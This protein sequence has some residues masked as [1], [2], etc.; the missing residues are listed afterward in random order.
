MQV[1]GRDY[2]LLNEALVNAFGF[3]SLAQ[4]LQ[5]GLEERLEELVGRGSLDTTVFKLIDAYNRRDQVE[6]LVQAARRFNPSNGTLHQV[7]QSLGRA[8]Q[9]TAHIADSV[10]DVEAGELEKLVRRRIP[11]LSVR[12]MREQMMRVEGQMCVIERRSPGGQGVARGSGFLIGPDA[13]LTNYHVVS[14]YLQDG[15][16][17]NLQVRFD[18]LLQEEG[19][20]KPEE[21]VVVSVDEIPIACPYTAGDAGNVSQPPAPG[22][23]DFA[24]LLLA[25]EAGRAPVG[26]D[27]G[28]MQS[29]TERGWMQLPDPAPELAEGDPLII[30]QYPGGRE[31]MMAIDT[32]AVVGMAW[33]DLRLRY[34]NNT[35]PGSSGS[36]VFTLDWELVALHHAG[37]PGR[38][39]ASYNQG[40][41]MAQIRSYLETEQLLHLLGE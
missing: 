10:T 1:K 6:K 23:L 13:V 19:V 11:K 26:G 38:E 14:D 25:E 40:I 20:R 21:G 34:R 31:L 32:E 37:G 4:M 3:D 24:I 9:V 30:Y 8:T 7:A 15:Q 2:Q 41:P 16:A 18:A 36:P 39:P 33:N 27:A 29:K 35:E 22:E 28:P 17:K 12:K 5:F